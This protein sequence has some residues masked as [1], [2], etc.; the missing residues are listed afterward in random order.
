MGIDAGGILSK[1]YGRIL[2]VSRRC[3]NNMCDCPIKVCIKQYYIYQKPCY[4][5]KEYGKI[6]IL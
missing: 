1:Q 3:A 6:T 5:L 2:H 4:T